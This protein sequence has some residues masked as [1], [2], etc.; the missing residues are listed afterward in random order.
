MI[1]PSGVTLMIY[2]FLACIAGVCF[3]LSYLINKIFD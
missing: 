2:G 3:G 1:I